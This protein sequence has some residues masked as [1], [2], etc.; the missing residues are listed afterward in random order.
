LSRYLRLRSWSLSRPVTAPPE[1]EVV[2]NAPC[3]QCGG[4]AEPEQDG[5]IVFYAC[6]CGAE[7]GYR[8]AASGTFCAAGLP[9]AGPEPGPPVIAT[10]IKRR[11]E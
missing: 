6:P 7:F 11:P 3:P 4:S 2:E 8:K 10:T 9:L 1:P 5:E